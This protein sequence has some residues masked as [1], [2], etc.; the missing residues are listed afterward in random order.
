MSMNNQVKVALVTG[1]S[2]GLGRQT[3][4][5]LAKSGYRIVLHGRNRKQLEITRQA[6]ESEGITAK[7]VA[8]D[9]TIMDEVESM[10]SWIIKEYG[11]LDVL[12]TNASLTMETEFRETSAIAFRNVVD[13]HIYGSIFP[14]MAAFDEIKANKGSIILISS[15]AGLHGLPRFS[16]YC[17]GKMALTAFW[18]SLE[19]EQKKSGLHLGLVHLP[20]VQNDPNKT[21]VNGSGE[22]EQMPPRPTGIQQSQDKVALGIY[23]AIRKRKKRI[24]LS[25]YGKMFAWVIRI[26]P[27]LSFFMISKFFKT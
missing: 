2:R 16:A 23:N 1:S 21:L 27:R 10:I 14:I 12:V 17:T 9:V 15:L 6:F 7:T 25:G 19:M 11:R 3:A 5:L 4:K 20:F 13:S 24:V 26:F 8:A 22:L 18:Q